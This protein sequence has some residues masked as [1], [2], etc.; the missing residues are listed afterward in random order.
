MA[1]SFEGFCRLI[2]KNILKIITKIFAELQ[3]YID[4][5]FRNHARTT[6]HTQS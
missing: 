5:C 2:M 3:N 6:N 1:Y 4:L